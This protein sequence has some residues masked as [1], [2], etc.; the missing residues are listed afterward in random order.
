MEVMVRDGQKR[1]AQVRRRR[2]LAP[3][4]FQAAALAL[5]AALALAVAP[6]YSVAASPAAPLAAEPSS[7]ASANCT[8][9]GGPDVGRS[10]SG[11]AARNPVGKA[12]ADLAPA[13]SSI[14]EQ[15]PGTDQPDIVK[16]DGQLLVVLRQQP[17]AVQ[18]MDLAQVP[19]QNN[20]VSLLPDLGPADGLLLSNGLVIVVGTK[21]TL[22]P[23]VA[24]A[25]GSDK[26][27]L[28]MERVSEE[29]YA[30]V[31][32]LAVPAHPSVE[33]TLFFDGEL[34]GARLI[35]GR[36]F[37]VLMGSSALF[38]PTTGPKAA[39]SGSA[40]RSYQGPAP[41]PPCGPGEA[42]PQAVVAPVPET[43]TVASFDPVGTSPPAHVTVGLATATYPY[44]NLYAS[45]V[46]P[47]GSDIFVAVGGTLPTAP[48]PVAADVVS[49]C[50]GPVVTPTCCSGGPETGAAGEPTVPG[51]CCP[52]EQGT[53]CPM[54]LRQAVAP[55]VPVV[56]TSST[57]IYGFAVSG[58]PGLRYLGAG[59]V[60]GAVLGA[61]SLSAWGSDV[62][63]VSAV[64]QAS[65][66]P[67][68]PGARSG[69]AVAAVAASFP[70]DFVTILRAEGGA[71]VTVGALRW[72]LGAGTISA[73]LFDGD[74][75]YVAT[76]SAPTTVA[77][78]L[79]TIDL[80]N[81]LVPKLLG[82]T[83]LPLGVNA[84]EPLSDGLFAGL[85]QS[86]PS[87][88]HPGGLQVD[89][90]D[91]SSTGSPSVVSTD[92]LA[93]GTSSPAE[94]DPQALSWWPRSDLLV[95][96]VDSATA[97]G[98]SG[99]ADLWSVD[100]SGALDL[101]G[102]VA[103]PATAPAVNLPGPVG[104]LHPEIER[105][106]VTGQYL[107]TVSGEGTL[108]SDLSSLAQVEWAPFDSGAA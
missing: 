83:S 71:L 28:P 66:H 92:L 106:V 1:G 79:Y 56:G 72:A 67:L 49:E 101:L 13:H 74:S 19:P 103:Q 55:V 23:V 9:T 78:T 107:F 87:G 108:V 34:E 54:L 68:T 24:R 86:P 29:T 45:A 39:A 96:P 94:S 105:A 75:A 93:A 47:N 85:G 20:G 40:S 43:L 8:A 25:T 26:T 35:N 65:A 42:G 31:V 50:C 44:Q 2:A 52:V 84:L 51:I 17:P 48:C 15:E 10:A 97:E 70:G 32:S 61:Y 76:N 38:A 11:V 5:V 98:V 27:S 90:I 81:P 82:A 16:T 95:V 7:L 36:V 60:P 41:V 80:S 99:T 64:A 104:G 62:G 4:S 18:V 3:C 73:V 30:E 12:A 33:R 88:T 37:L 22:L 89:V 63:I 14:T 102:S 21:L 59:E 58:T 46:Y 91:G 69:G 100:P 77:S 53:A 57:R 6:V